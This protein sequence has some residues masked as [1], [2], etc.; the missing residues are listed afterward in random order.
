ML[1]WNFGKRGAHQIWKLEVLEEDV[2]NLVLAHG[3]FEVVFRFSGGRRVF[4]GASAL[5]RRRFLDLV[6]RY[7]FLIAGQ[8][9]IALAAFLGIKPE[10]RL[11]C[12]LRGDA[13]FAP[14]RDVSDTRILQ[15]F[16]YRFATLS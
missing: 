5:A 12:P 4:A 1:R 8:H 3:E 16:L 6:A 13:D 14:L 15:T 10:A 9:E 7:E 2:E 11:F